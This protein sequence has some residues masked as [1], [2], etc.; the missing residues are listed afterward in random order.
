MDDLIE[1]GAGLISGDPVEVV[2]SYHERTK[3]Y[4]GRYARGPGGL[5]WASQP[6]PFRRF[7]G[8]PEVVLPLASH[9]VGV[10]CAVLVGGGEVRSRELSLATLGGF[11]ELAMGLSA[12]KEMGGDGWYLRMNPSSGNLHPTELYLLL[13]ALEGIG[14][15]PGLYHYACREH[16]LERR[17]EW[18]R[19][20]G[21]GGFWVG[22]SSVL[23][24]EAWKYGERAFRYCQH[25][26]GHALGALR[27]AAATLG[28][29]VRLCAG[30]RGQE[31]G[32]LLGVDR[33]E[34][35]R[36]CEEEAEL[37]AWVGVDGRGGEEGDPDAGEAVT[38]WGRANRLS[39]DRVEWPVIGAV[40]RASG[41]VAG[42]GLVGGIR[43]EEHWGEVRI[44]ECGLGAGEVIRR[45]RSAVAFDG[46]TSVS[47]EQFLTILDATLPRVGGALF[48]VWPL[49]VRVHLVLFVH[50]VEGLPSGLYLWLRRGEDLEGLKLAMGVE[51]KWERVAGLD[52]GVP[53]YALAE[54][55]LREFAES[56][57]CMQS[58]AADSAFSLG[59]LGRFESAIGEG[60]AGVYREL[61]W[62][63]GLVGQALY[64][65]AEMAGVRG[66][67]IGCYFDDML[68]RA[69]RLEGREWQSLY[70]FTVG[71]PV[72]DGRLR[73]VAPYVGAER[74]GVS[75]KR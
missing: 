46:E 63:A 62:E 10:G 25:D 53:L 70:H 45:R 17:A 44:P 18:G 35:F 37:L 9:E 42:R 71:G 23:W 32:R 51:A 58:I 24:R 57:S 69:L 14:E 29:S 48:D 11:L 43:R 21:E 36:G 55:D 67:G 52:E 33:E 8:A 74:E 59:M 72:E 61:F 75:A 50:R 41:G 30:L 39:R 49:A 7:A 40:A 3:H 19:W 34:D 6:D 13:P 1:M 66:T 65:G 12:R 22:L 27:Y 15:Q 73:T 16:V 2:F 4:P 28:W 60:G 47:R 26:V 31:L 5:D 20:N 68:H 64:L 56:V 54:G 38:W